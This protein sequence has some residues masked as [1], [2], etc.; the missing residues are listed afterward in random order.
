MPVKASHDVQK[1]SRKITGGSSAFDPRVGAG[2]TC[3]HKEA[4]NLFS[5]ACVFVLISQL[6]WG[7]RILELFSEERPVG[8][9]AGPDSG[10][11][12][13]LLLVEECSG[14][15]EDGA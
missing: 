12:G 4:Q 6:G 1:R 2:E 13:L 15:E 5:G 14:C 10:I 11:L 9:G 7:N 8:V 3:S